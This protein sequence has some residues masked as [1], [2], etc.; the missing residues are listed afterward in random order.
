M[1]SIRVAPARALLVVTLL[2]PFLFSAC[3]A[4]FTETDVRDFGSFQV[5]VTND[6]A[7]RVQVYLQVDPGPD[8]G[9]ASETLLGGAPVEGTTVYR[10][11]LEDRSASHRLRAAM[12][13]NRELLSEAFV[14]GELAGVRWTLGE[15]ELTRETEMDE[16]AGEG[17]G[18][19]GSVTQ[20]PGS[21]HR[22]PTG[23]RRIPPGF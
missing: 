9:A 4:G 20:S 5:E 6:L 18:T 22:R 13:R 16:Q 1:I 2:C 19:G 11:D 23:A 10:I 8:S 14:P 12:P 21:V 15:N 17:S 3:A 7:P